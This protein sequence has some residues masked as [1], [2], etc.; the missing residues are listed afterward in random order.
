[1]FDEYKAFAGTHMF[2][3]VQSVPLSEMEKV[4]VCA[5][6]GV[7][8]VGAMQMANRLE[9]YRFIIHVGYAMRIHSRQWKR[10]SACT[11]L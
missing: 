7:S 5:W 10:R 1:M 3:R 9:E 8:T 2:D 4:I 6:R 11:V